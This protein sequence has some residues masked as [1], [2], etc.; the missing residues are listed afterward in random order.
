M[1]D[2]Y[3][4]D[5]A[6]VL[7][8]VGLTV[9]E[10]DGWRNR[11]RGSGGYDPGRPTHVMVHHTASP[12][13]ASGESDA[14]YCATG[15]E[16]APLSNVCLDRDGVWWVLAA[17]ATNTNGKGGPID[18]VPADSMNTYAIGVEANGGYGSPWP[19][20]QTRSYVTGVA[21]LCSAY[22][23]TYVRAHAEWAP[24]RKIDPAGPSPWATGNNTWDMNAFRADVKVDGGSG[25]QPDGGD[26]DMPLSDDDVKRIA[27]AVW[28]HDVG[29]TRA[30]SAINIIQGTV[31]AFLGGWKDG[32]PPP[33]RT[34]LQQIHDDTKK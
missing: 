12:P 26:D 23:C 32:T 33:S 24:D 2:R 5:L 16:D 15:D 6:D 21:A 30:W 10:L 20:V 34:L 7:R 22:G 4:T 11:S 13:S 8:A 25:F 14:W 1:G 29:G 18:C 19:D 31:R 28:S 17:G 3:L 9:I 27:D